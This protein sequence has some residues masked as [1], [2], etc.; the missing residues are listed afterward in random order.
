MDKGTIVY[1]NWYDFDKQTEYICK[2]KVADNSSYIGTQW[3]HYIN[4]RF[5]PPGM[6]VSICRHFS[7]DKLSTD[8]SNVP[9]DDCYLIC[10]KKTRFFEHDPTV[11][12]R[13]PEKLNASDAWQQVQQF[14]H[15]HWDYD[16]GHIQLTY[17]DSFYQLWHD[18]IAAKRGIP[19]QCQTVLPSGSSHPTPET[20]QQP[21]KLTAKQRHSTGRIQYTDSIQTSLFD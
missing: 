16:H 12:L 14:K 8:S 5:Q 4:V 6:S 2:G 7:I 17:I 18:A 9:H 13:N 15:D 1:L 10:G 21:T 11:K 20:P 3:E 19:L